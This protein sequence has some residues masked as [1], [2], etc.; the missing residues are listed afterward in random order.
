MIDRIVIVGNGIAAITAIKS[1][2]ETDNSSEI[3]LIG[4]EKSY[5]YNRIRLS[6]GLLNSLEEDKILLQKK[7]WYDSN[8]IKLYLNTKVVSI[9]T[10][11]KIVK[12]SDGKTINYTKLLLAHGS[13]NRKP[14]I[15]GIEKPGVHALRTLQDALE[16]KEQLKDSNKVLI[17]GGGIQGLE[18]AWIISQMDKEVTISHRSERLMSKQLDENA[19]DLLERAIRLNGV[20]ILFNSQIDEIIGLDKV[21]GFKTTNGETYEC[22]TVV[23]SIGTEPNIDIIEDTP[24]NT[25]AGIIV[26]EKMQTNVKDIYAAGD[27]AEYDNKIFGLRSIAMDQGKVAGYNISGKDSIYKYAIPS[28]TLNAFNLSLFS[29]GVVENSKA[30]DTVTENK[31]DENIY[32]KVLINNN[33]VIGTIITNNMKLFIPLKSAIEKG[34]SLA[35]IEYN[36]ISFDDLIKAIKEK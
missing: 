27:V 4:E 9:D 2:R 19:S 18:I 26:N 16:I 17:I 35:G 23:Y 22:D 24:I 29:I 32:N 30:T 34:I 12:L 31:S 14:S 21:E 5:P 25:N 13:H 8:N 11:K 7:D 15:S 1:I 10:N 28:T 6:K 3:H 33:K 20:D 36:N